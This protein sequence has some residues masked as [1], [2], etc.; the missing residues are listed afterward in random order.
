MSVVSTQKTA[1]A[2]LHTNRGDISIDL[3]GNHAPQTVDNFVGLAKGTKDYSERN[4]SGGEEGPFYDGAIFH[5][6]IDG[7]MIQGGD[8]TGTG[9]G[10]PGYRFGDEFHPELQF[11][12]PYLLAMA[13]AGPGTNGSQ[14][15]ITVAPTPHLNNHHTI[16]GE[17]TDADSQKV[18][19]T[20][21]ETKTDRFDRPLDDIVIDSVEIVE[22]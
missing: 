10:G 6:V 11:D 9:R 16:F 18:V 12:R 22:N 8:P 19:D 7:F 2:I 15:F 5:R 14:F 1:T 13:N 21:A 3:F 17:V 20:I 4:A